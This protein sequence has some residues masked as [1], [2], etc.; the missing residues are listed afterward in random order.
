MK[1]HIHTIPIYDAFKT[2]DGCPFC[3]LVFQA[4]RMKLESVLNDE[5]AMDPG[6]REW[7]DALGFCKAH[8]KTMIIMRDAMSLAL[9]LESR[10]KRLE[11]DLFE[12]THFTYKAAYKSADETVDRSLT[13]CYICHEVEKTMCLYF[14][15]V[16]DLWR[17]DADFKILFEAQRYFCL[18][19]FRSLVRE[20]NQMLRKNGAAEF[21]SS[22]SD[23]VRKYL[24]SLETDARKF[25]KSFN[26]LNSGIDGEAK[27]VM[28]RTVAF[29]T[30]SSGEG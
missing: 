28:K 11:S 8:L 12:S 23:V 30:G 6:L 17:T 27:T 21:F 1:E 15:T 5:C 25:H 16:I 29:L 10:L 2:K 22:A 20:S 18:S 3:T 4:E 26:Y 19:H 24:T 13:S 9:L 7:T 14:G